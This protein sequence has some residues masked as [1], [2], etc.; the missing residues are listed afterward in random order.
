MVERDTIYLIGHGGA[1]EDIAA[2]QAAYAPEVDWQVRRVESV[3]ALAQSANTL[4]ED[5]PAG[6]KVFVAVDANAINYARL[7]LYG[8]AKLRGYRLVT[9][10]HPKAYVAPDARLGDNVWIGP[11]VIV[12]RG[13]KVAGDVMVNAGVR[14]DA[15]VQI[16][17]H[18]WIGPGASIGAATE[19]GGHCVLGADVHVSAGLQIGKHCML[20]QPGLWTKSLPA[21]SFVEPG[22]TEPA[23]MIGAGYSWQSRRT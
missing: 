1:F 13:C 23:R 10:V 2:D 11:G 5:L 18:G 8:P 14:L 12:S 3:A 9:L 15:G 4:L 20:T 7:E 17:A 22:Y 16:G 21:G 19:V 6:A